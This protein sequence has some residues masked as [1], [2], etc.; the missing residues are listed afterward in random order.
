MHDKFSI[1]QSRIN[2]DGFSQFCLRTCLEVFISCVIVCFDLRPYPILHE[3][4]MKQQTKGRIK[5]GRVH[6]L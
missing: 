2:Q 4:Q 3:Q 6:I 1:I 5:K